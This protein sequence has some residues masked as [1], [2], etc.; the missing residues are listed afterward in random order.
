M[1]YTSKRQPTSD[2]ATSAGKMALTK[3]DF[4]IKIDTLT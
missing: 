3:Q 4:W 2:F 1:S